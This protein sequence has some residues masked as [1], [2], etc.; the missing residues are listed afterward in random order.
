MNVREFVKER[1]IR[2][3]QGVKD[4]QDEIGTHLAALTSSE[5]LPTTRL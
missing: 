1:F 5:G 3:L 4:F 2:V